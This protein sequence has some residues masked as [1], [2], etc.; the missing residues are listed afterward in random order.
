MTRPVI[1]AGVL[2]LA[3]SPLAGAAS[4]VRVEGVFV[5]A[6]TFTEV[7]EA[8]IGQPIR[9]IVSVC[10]VSDVP[11]GVAGGEVNVTWNSTIIS[12]QDS[13]DA[14]NATT[15]DVSPLFNQSV[16][17]WGYT[18]IRTGTGA[19]SGMG[20][21]QGVPPTISLDDEVVFFTLNFLPIKA[22]SAGVTLSGHDFGVIV[23]DPND[24]AAP[25]QAVNPVLTVKASVP[26]PTEDPNDVV[27]PGVGCFGPPLAA[28]L[29]LGTGGLWSSAH[30]RRRRR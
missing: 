11:T 26:D 6:G 9:L 16:W 19:L 22:G 30:R 8:E 17:T 12:L 1:I 18:G 28:A 20:A 3:L 23:V 4:G 13:V 15:S 21:A 5:R 27:E 2:V 25:A 14:T 24:A 29:L 10:D 7:T